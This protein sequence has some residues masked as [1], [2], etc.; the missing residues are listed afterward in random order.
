V[1]IPN[2]VE[3]KRIP[4]REPSLVAPARVSL[5][6]QEGAFVVGT[7]ASFK[8]QKRLDVWLRAARQIKDA[9]PNATFVLVGDGPL[10]PELEDLAASLGLTRSSILFAGLQRDVASYL[11]SFDVFMLSSDHEGLPIALLEAMAAQCAI[12]ATSVGGIPEALGEE[13]RE[14]LV[15][16]QNPE[17]LALRVVALSDRT[18]RERLGTQARKRV[19]DRFGMRQMV[20]ALERL[21]T[22][23]LEPE[24][25]SKRADS[26]TPGT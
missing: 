21:Y 10:R 17:A 3:V 9:I 25:A 24:I 20:S 6:I 16:P 19:E 26:V 14:W 8:R 1:V 18:L 7:V 12:V 5:G 4:T 2:G 15:P 11:T 22:E 13:L 23:A